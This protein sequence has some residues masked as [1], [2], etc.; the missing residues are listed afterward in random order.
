MWCN[1]SSLSRPPK[2]NPHPQSSNN[3]PLKAVLQVIHRIID[4]LKH[5][6]ASLKQCS[7]VAKSWHPR[8]RKWLFAEI[9]IKSL[10]FRLDLVH[11]HSPDLSPG[12]CHDI[13][14][15]LALAHIRER[16]AGHYASAL[17]LVQHPWM[18]WIHP[19]LLIH[20]SHHFSI[21][22]NVTSL[23]I[24]TLPIYL[25]SQIELRKV[26]GHFFQTV[27]ELSLEGPQS[28]PHDLIAFL[29]HFSRL[30]SLTI[31]DPEW[32][33]VRQFIF[34]PRKASPP[35]KGTLV[36]IRFDSNSSLF[37]QLLSRLSLRFR[38]LSIVGCSLGRSE[39]DPLLDCLGE[40][41]RSLAV[42]AWFKGVYLTR[43]NLELS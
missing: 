25:F 39:F 33:E 10:D 28:D 4:A 8:S 29:R 17:H 1:P 24:D 36:L 13:T 23:T 5:D 9:V 34:H 38:Q 43:P 3:P 30:D 2:M 32:V 42:S 14:F 40:S 15:A 31:S 16:T 12:M 41:L 19:H 11:T 37:V 21:F 27:T 7:L 18:M 26:F 35:C 22:A 6:F 20:F